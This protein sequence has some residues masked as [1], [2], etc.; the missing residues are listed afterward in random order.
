MRFWLWGVA[1]AIDF[2]TP[3]CGSRHLASA[4]PD[5]AHLPERFGLFTLILLGEAMV[6]VMRGMESQEDWTPIAAMSAFAA[7]AAIFSLWWWYFD[8][9]RGAEPRAVRTTADT[10]RFHVWTYAHLPLY[11]GIGV[12]GVGLSHAIQLAPHVDAATGVVIFGALSVAAASIAVIGGPGAAD[13]AARNTLAA[14]AS[15][16]GS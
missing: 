6:G 1:L 9:A 14:T 13:A 4:P 2:A 16:L 10:R 3:I 5:G 7:M 15:S 12:T 8:V 11:L